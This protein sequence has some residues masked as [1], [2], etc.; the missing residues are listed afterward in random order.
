[1][2]AF[3]SITV[4]LLYLELARYFLKEKVPIVKQVFD[5][6]FKAFC[7]EREKSPN[8]FIITHILLL[9]GYFLIL[10]IYR[11]ALPVTA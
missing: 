10:Y 9:M 2:F 3:N 4:L 8:A 7:D 6:Y 5:N 1:V 11:C